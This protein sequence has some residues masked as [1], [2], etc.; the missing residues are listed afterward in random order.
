MA[1]AGHEMVGQVKAQHVMTVWVTVGSGYG[2]VGVGSWQRRGMK[3]WDRLR[4][5]GSRQRQ[6]TAW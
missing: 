5:C 2:M 4:Q 6:G 1:E 3:G